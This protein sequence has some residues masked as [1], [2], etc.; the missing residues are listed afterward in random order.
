M[1]HLTR[2]GMLVCSTAAL[3]ATHGGVAAS[4]EY[5]GAIPFLDPALRK[6]IQ[7]ALARAGYYR[8]AIDGQVGRGT[9]RA[10]VSFRR[11][12]GI[13]ADGEDDSPWGANMHI[14][15]G[16]GEA[17]LNYPGGVQNRLDEFDLMAHLG[18]RP[19]EGWRAAAFDHYMSQ[20]PPK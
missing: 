18:V 10:I 11:A 17:L 15:R 20:R 7:K 14:D 12:K 3:L 2:R 5:I 19:S 16:L 4:D 9:R 13:L 1:R 8:G 6:E